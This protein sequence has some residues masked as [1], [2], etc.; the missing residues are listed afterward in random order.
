MTSPKRSLKLGPFVKGLNTFSDP[1]AVPDDGLAE[2]LNMELDLDGSLVSRPPIAHLS[3]DLPLDAEGQLML[4]GYFYTSVGFEYLLATDGVS[5]TYYFSGTSWT[6]ITDTFAAST[7]AQFDDKAWL[8]AAPGSANPG[9]TWT[10]TAGFVAVPDMPKGSVI[11]ALKARLWIAQGEL[12]TSN[13]TRLYYSNV[14]G[15]TPFWKPSPDFIDVAR[16][17]GQTIVSLQ[18]Y[19]DSLL[20][21]RTASIYRYDYSIEPGDGQITLSIGA[22]GLDSRY[23]IARY[24][25]AFYFSY[26][27]RA[28]EYLNGR[29]QE[30]GQAITFTSAG[31]RTGIIIPL[32]VSVFGGRAIFTYYDTLYVFSLTTRTWS[33]WRS[34]ARGAIAR[35]LERR[36]D[37]GEPTQA[38]A[39]SNRIPPKPLINRFLNPSFEKPYVRDGF[40]VSDEW[41]YEGT[42]SL[43][44]LTAGLFPASTLF[45]SPVLYPVE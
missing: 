35:I 36:G 1:S 41:A 43:F 42:H 45:P 34:V 2:A 31:T 17:D 23:S 3:A 33:R 6:L 26:N 29:A 44:V 10:P 28:Y 19:F 40:R 12:A 38:Y 11:V 21:F 22:I 16:G 27:D 39:M 18:V 30:I 15:S 8:V 14:L 9:G 4:L 32:A 7:M 24:E 37:A 5:K 20:I 13:G 25:N